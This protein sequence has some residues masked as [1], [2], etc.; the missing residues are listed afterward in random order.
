[1]FAPPKIACSYTYELDD[2]VFPQQLKQF[3]PKAET[4]LNQP[5]LKTQLTAEAETQ[6]NPP[7]CGRRDAAVITV[8]TYSSR[9]SSETF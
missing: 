8:Y 5:K 4:Q 1:L 7:F 2:F 3:Q 6:L 9:A